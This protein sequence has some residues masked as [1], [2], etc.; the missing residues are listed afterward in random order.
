MASETSDQGWPWAKEYLGPPGNAAEHTRFVNGT[1][2]ISNKDGGPAESFYADFDKN[3]AAAD[4]RWIG[5]YGALHAGPMNTVCFN[6]CFMTTCNCG[7]DGRVPG[8]FRPRARE[9]E[10]KRRDAS[11]RKDPQ[12]MPPAV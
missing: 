5:W 4:K 8:F 1:G 9:R 2:I 3:L 6:D 11:R 7:R 10:R 12:P